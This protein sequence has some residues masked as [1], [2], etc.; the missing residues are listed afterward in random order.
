MLPTLT[1]D[2]YSDRNRE[3]LA[4]ACPTRKWI[5]RSGTNENNGTLSE[6]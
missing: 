1:I 5:S 4:K 2:V 6:L 3:G